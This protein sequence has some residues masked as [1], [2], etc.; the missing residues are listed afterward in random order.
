MRSDSV[1]HLEFIQF[2]HRSSLTHISVFFLF[3]DCSRIVL[4]HLLSNHPVKT[5]TSTA[6][7]KV[8]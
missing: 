4:L 8:G 7:V 5:P 2:E 1:Q 6:A 3:P